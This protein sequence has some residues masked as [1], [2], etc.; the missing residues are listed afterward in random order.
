MPRLVATWNKIEYRMSVTFY[1]EQKDHGKRF[2][3]TFKRMIKKFCKGR[4]YTWMMKYATLSS[5]LSP[6]ENMFMHNLQ[7]SFNWALGLRNKEPCLHQKP[8]R[9]VFRKNKYRQITD[10]KTLPEATMDH[11][12]LLTAW[13]LIESG[14]LVNVS[15]F[16]IGIFQIA[17][18]LSFRTQYFTI[19]LH[20]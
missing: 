3:D 16:E 13:M 8:P 18:T 17:Y 20:T 9:N 14:M 5:G 6:S 15:A 19:N 2:V 10:I 7:T 4:C 11:F 12:N 1:I